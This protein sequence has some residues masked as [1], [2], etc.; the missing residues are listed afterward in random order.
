MI[1][2]NACSALETRRNIE[3]LELGGLAPRTDKSLD[4]LL[5]I[6]KKLKV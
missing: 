2:F 6:L 5:K 3:I 1:C 4:E